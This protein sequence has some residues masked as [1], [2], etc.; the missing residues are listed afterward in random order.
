MP[1]STGVNRDEALALLK[2]GNARERL[3]AAR[4]FQ[5]S[6]Q[7][8]DAEDL[9]TA[10]EGESIV[11]VRSALQSALR[12]TTRHPAPST[13]ES[14]RAPAPETHDPTSEALDGVRATVVHD[15][16][17]LAV[18]LL[19]PIV[20]SLRVHAAA[21]IGS[22]ESS[23]TAA[24]ISRLRGLLQSLH[25]LGIASA[26]PQLQEVEVPSLVREVRQTEFAADLGRVDVDGPAA[27]TVVTDPTLLQLIVGVALRNALEAER[28]LGEGRV[29]C[30]WGRENGVVWIRA[31][32]NGRGLAA[33]P[34]NPFELGVSGKTGNSGIGLAIAAQA[35]RS[36]GADLD[37]REAPEGGCVFEVRLPAEAP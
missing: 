35:A 27:L 12:R 37:L 29:S 1:P 20:G 9:R 6:A 3:A 30:T 8:E 22:F 26:P 18:H 23:D 34:N 14:R 24:A 21:E 5:S 16:S 33:G 2:R 7:P 36:L 11:W 4:F 10:L 15:F 13:A 28:G 17:L 19:D 25:R 32:D 31:V